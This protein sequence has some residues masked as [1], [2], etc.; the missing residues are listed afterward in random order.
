MLLAFKLLARDWRSGELRILIAALVIAVAALTSV[1]IYTDRVAR[2]LDVQAATLLG[3]DLLLS[4]PSA[5]P[6]NWIV[7]ANHLHLQ[8]AQL[9]LFSTVVIAG[10]QMQ[11][12]SVKAVSADYPLRGK[13]RTTTTLNAADQEATGIP[14]AGTLWVDAQLLSLLHIPMGSTIKIGTAQFVIQR[15]LTAEPDIESNWL[16]IAPRVIMNAVDVAKTQVVVPGS[17][18]EYRLM[19]DGDPAQIQ[20]YKTWLTPQLNAGQKLLTVKDGRPEFKGVLQ[21]ANDYLNLAIIICILFAGV[22]IATSVRRYC[23]R[24]YDTVAL[25]RCLGM[26][27]QQVM[28]I[29]ATHLLTLGIL[30]AGLGC[31]VGYGAQVFFSQIFAHWLKLN[32]VSSSLFPIILGLITGLVIL[33][34]FAIPSFLRLKN[35]TV[36]RVLRRDQLPVKPSILLV[37]G[38]PLLA[39]TALIFWQTHDLHLTL[40]LLYS[41]VGAAVVLYGVAY[42]LIKLASKVRSQTGVSWRYGL[43][44]LSRHANTSAIQLVVFG[45]VIMVVLLTSIMRNDLLNTWQQQLPASSPNYFAINIQPSDV[46]GVTHLLDQNQTNPAGVYPMVRG[47]L[48][49]LN[50]IAIKQVVAPSARNNNA[51][52]RELNLSWTNQLPADNK[53]VSGQWWVATDQGKPLVSME[54]KL[55]NDLGI[56]LGDQLTFQ[57]GDQAITVTVHSMRTVDWSSFHPNFFM[58]FPPGFLNTMP[59]TYITSFHLAA[60]NKAVLTQLVQQFPSVTIIDVNEVLQQ[61]HGVMDQMSQVI[62]Y[63]LL[64]IF[65]AGIAVLYA[66][67]RASLD[68]RIY[69]GVIMR[70]LGANRRQLQTA[71]A[72][73]FISLGLLAGLFG[74]LSALLIG[75][76]VAHYVFKID[77]HFNYQI[78][79]FGIL[80]GAIVVGAIGL[81]A[82]R[83]LLQQPPITILREM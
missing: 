51:L 42:G 28:L 80:G 62:Q 65:L 55:A 38:L 40:I 50:H 22:A 32:L 7:Q 1:N 70:V 49:A 11:L 41:I 60:A 27:Q 77:Y 61:M 20:A 36:L 3:G 75:F 44:N 14:A 56:K 76:A 68:A 53:R 21:R 59:T 45:L 8:T 81:F 37:Y 57:I 43:A 82:T 46:A 72:S 18:V 12:A 16:N 29:F 63:L 6:A 10:N 2:T 19:F 13:L 58:I 71:L 69:E 66:A 67:L 25:L 47:R 73:E 31:L 15:I 9:L 33:M 78:I 4:T 34:G 35:I 79:A 5:P 30:A 26:R 48:V 23:E 39:I 54:Q 52:N 64:F 17:R 74:S 24:H 83:L